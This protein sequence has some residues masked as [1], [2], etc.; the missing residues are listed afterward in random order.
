MFVHGV[1]TLCL[2]VHARTTDGT[3]MGPLRLFFV[4]S[5][6]ENLDKQKNNKFS[7]TTGS[8]AKPNHAVTNGKSHN[9]C[10]QI[11]SCTQAL[12]WDTQIVFFVADDACGKCIS[13][14][15]SSPS[16]I[17]ILG[18]NSLKMT[19]I[20]S[21]VTC[22]CRNLISITVRHLVSLAVMST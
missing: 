6:M 7:H 2:R 16:A 15:C 1:P 13:D 9:F 10:C 8:N 3:P 20:L 5:V 14:L 12:P 22:A 11:R 4:L 17:I 19:V 18:I 21:P